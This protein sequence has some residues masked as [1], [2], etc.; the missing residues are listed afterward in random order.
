[1]HT[2]S[3]A[4]LEAHG[5]LLAELAMP[6]LGLYVQKGVTVGP[7]YNYRYSCPV[8]NPSCSAP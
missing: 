6:Q 7:F 8:Y 1:M 5:T 3:S 2:G 4:C